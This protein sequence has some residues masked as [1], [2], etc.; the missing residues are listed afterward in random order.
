VY[1]EAVPN[2]WPG[3]SKASVAKYVAR[4]WNSARSVGGR[5]EWTSWTFRNQVY[6]VSQVP[7]GIRNMPAWSRHVSGQEASATDS[8]LARCGPSSSSSEKPSGGILDGLNFADEAVRQAIDQW[9]AIVQATWYECLDECSGCFVCQWA[10]H[11]SE[12]AQ[13]VETKRQK[14]A[15]YA[16]SDSFESITTPRLLSATNRRWLKYVRCSVSK[17]SISLYYFVLVDPCWF[18]C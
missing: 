17:L 15:T 12:L 1:S 2:P 13:V 18:V 9:I 5:A 14:A 11:W 8:E 16:D 3:S 4:A 10:E 7:G 6:V